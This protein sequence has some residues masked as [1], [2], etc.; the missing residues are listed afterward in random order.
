MPNTTSSTGPLVSSSAGSQFCN[1]FSAILTEAAPTK[2]PPTRP[3]P[4]STAMNRYSMPIC[5]PNG[6]GLTER[7]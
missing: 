6:D 2:A 1:W 4:P 3:T 7:W 5:S